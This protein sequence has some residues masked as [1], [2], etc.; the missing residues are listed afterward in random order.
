MGQT[1]D[2]LGAVGICCTV[3]GLSASKAV[4]IEQPLTADGQLHGASE[5]DGFFTVV[6]RDQD[7]VRPLQPLRVVLVPRGEE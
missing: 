6:H 4:G 7:D 3:C 2:G 1:D 5:D